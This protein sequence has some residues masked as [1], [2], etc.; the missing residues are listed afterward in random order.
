MATNLKGKG[1]FASLLLLHGEKIAIAVVGLAV[2][3]FIYGSLKVD[4]LGDSFQAD[5]LQSEVTQ[6]S[7]EIKS[8]DWKK[9]VTDH[10][11]KVKTAQPIAAKGDLS[12]N[13]KDY[14]PSDPKGQPN[15]SIESAIVAPLIL[16]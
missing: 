3:W 15:F 13:V 2:L 1:R 8:F 5:K 16:R 4:K 12:I 11:D 14:V 9:A 10:P 6:T 7:S